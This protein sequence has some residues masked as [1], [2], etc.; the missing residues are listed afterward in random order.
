MNKESEDKTNE[1]FQR[2]PTINFKATLSDGHMHLSEI[3]FNDKYLEGLGYSIDTFAVTTLRDGM[4][5]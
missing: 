5:Q 3:V 4:P 2:Y 1:F